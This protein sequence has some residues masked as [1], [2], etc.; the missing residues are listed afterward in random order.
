MK[1]HLNFFYG[2]ILCFFSVSFEAFAS[3]VEVPIRNQLPILQRLL[4]TETNLKKNKREIVAGVIYQSNVRTSNQTKN[5]LFT[6]ARNERVTIGEAALRLVPINIDNAANNI[7]DILNG[8]EKYHFLIITQLRSVNYREI[9]RYSTHKSVLTFA[10]CVD[11]MRNHKFSIAIGY[12]GNSPQIIVNLDTLQAEG[13]SFP[14]Q[15]LRHVRR[16]SDD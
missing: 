10:T 16:I 9:S 5:E 1:S 11:V 2:I 3:E 13:F 7:Y 4:A 14:S 8:G 15:V 12:K 6:F